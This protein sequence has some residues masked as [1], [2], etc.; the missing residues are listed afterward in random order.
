MCISNVYLWLTSSLS[1]KI[2]SHKLLDHL[3]ADLK[4][5]GNRNGMISELALLYELYS[6]VTLYIHFVAVVSICEIFFFFTQW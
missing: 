1:Q 2:V 4:L 6:L 5:V 3:Y